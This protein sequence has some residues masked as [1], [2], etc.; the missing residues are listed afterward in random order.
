MT[1]TDLLA[2]LTRDGMARQFFESVV[3]QKMIGENPF[4][5][6]KTG[7][8][9]NEARKRFI[10]REDIEKVFEECPDDE[11]RLLVA[12]SRFGGLRIPSEALALRWCDVNWE[13]ERF[14]VTS[15]KTE[16]HQGLEGRWVPIFPELRPFLSKAFDEAKE[17]SVYVITRYRDLD[18]NLRTQFLRIIKRAGLT[19]WPKPFHN[20]RASRETELANAYPLH[21]AC[22]C[23]GNTASIAQKQY[24]SVTEDHFKLATKGGAKSGALEA[25]NQAQK[26]TATDR[27]ESRESSEVESDNE[28]MQLVAIGD[29]A[30]QYA[31]RD[32]NPQ[33][34]AP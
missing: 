26:P 20:L 29:E 1:A 28:D 31:W 4:E 3:R 30:N 11:Y 19:P 27:N 2:Q 5:D 12:L 16:H 23:I 17:G 33:P 7:G 15:S 21:V 32:S 8:E 25:Q 34:T 22:A 10:P 13:K 6:V 18:A 14:W 9:T 24:L